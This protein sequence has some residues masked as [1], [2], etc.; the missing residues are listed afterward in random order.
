MISSF[1]YYLRQSCFLELYSILQLNFLGAGD[2]WGLDVYEQD[3]QDRQ[4]VQMN[5][6]H[7]GYIEY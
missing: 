7:T 2:G 3:W 1:S 5:V 6:T 4:F